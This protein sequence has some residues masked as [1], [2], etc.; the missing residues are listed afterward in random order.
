[1]RKM[2][3]LFCA[4]LMT[5]LLVS[6]VW[7]EPELNFNYSGPLDNFTGEPESET[8]AQVGGDRIRISSGVC[9]DR[10]L[11]A[12][13]HT[14]GSE[15]VVSNIASGMIT[16]SAVTLNIPDSMPC[17][18]YR[19]GEAVQD[20]ALPEVKKPGA[21]VLMQ[22]MDSESA[23]E[24]MRFT[25]VKPV[26]GKLE[27]FRVPSGFIITSASFNGSEMPHSE[28]SVSMADEGEYQINYRCPA[29]ETSYSFSVTADHTAPT[30]LLAEVQPDGRAKGP[31]SIAD[32]EP[33]AT[34]A[35]WLNGKQM[36]YAETLTGSGAYRLI[37]ADEAGNTNTYQFVIQVYFN[38]SSLIFFFIFLA[39]AAGVGI[40]VLYKR[41]HLRVR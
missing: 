29:A 11:R 17:I 33:G 31:V 26:T 19:D 34:I 15:D 38:V 4:V 12:F 9:Y 5:A 41:R 24:I 1:M 39:L 18:L 20:E 14:S 8:A 40:Y 25:I 6:T 13:V 35:I 28:Y 10:N 32:L 21:Y 37:V 3:A 22:G 7:A 23:T 36:P 27:S 16:G 30:L 2:I